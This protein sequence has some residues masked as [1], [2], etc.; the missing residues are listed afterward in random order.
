VNVAVQIAL[1]ASVFIVAAGVLG[2]SL[3]NARNAQKSQVDALYEKENSALR[4]ALDRQEGENQRIS[5]KYDEI[6][7]ANLVLQS[8]VSGAEEV[9]KLAVEIAG[10]EK[11]RQ[12][13]HQVMMVLI[14]DLIAEF[15]NSRGAIGR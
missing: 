5:V 15:R 14:K 4:L 11:K 10:E 6:A 2:V 1:I 9:R 3:A 12:E 13:E 7:K 8:T